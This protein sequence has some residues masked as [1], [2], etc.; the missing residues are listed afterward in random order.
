MKLAQMGMLVCSLSTVVGAFPGVGIHP[1][2]WGHKKYMNSFARME[3]VK[4]YMFYYGDKYGNNYDQY[5]LEPVSNVSIAHYTY[6]VPKLDRE[7]MTPTVCFEF[8]RTIKGM[9][10]FALKNGR[11]CY[12]EPFHEPM[13]SDSSNCDAVCDGDN[14]LTCGGVSKSEV[15]SM[16]DLD[17]CGE[18]FCPDPLTITTT[19]TPP[20]PIPNIKCAELWN[21]SNGDVSGDTYVFKDVIEGYDLVLKPG[22]D[23]SGLSVK[24]NSEHTGPS[25]TKADGVSYGQIHVDGVG[26]VVVKFILRPKKRG[27]KEEEDGWK[28]EVLYAD[29]DRPENH[30]AEEWIGVKDIVKYDQLGMKDEFADVEFTTEY[31]NGG[32]GGKGGASFLEKPDDD[33]WTWFKSSDEKDEVDNPDAFVGKSFHLTAS[34]KEAA[35]TAIYEDRLA[36]DVKLAIVGRDVVHRNYMFSGQSSRPGYKDC[37]DFGK[38]VHA[39]AEQPPLVPLMR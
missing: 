34:Q 5:K 21:L 18:P 19:T 6:Y 2:E 37:P 30:K 15:Y 24:L 36:W 1:V 26:D 16:H 4:D 25:P 27:V 35:F 20:E 17:P 22:K 29:L 7:L 9:Q 10:F 32:K 31:G 13:E 11:D 14:S 39:Q 33:A 12:C 28:H 3:C 38:L 23:R 8:C